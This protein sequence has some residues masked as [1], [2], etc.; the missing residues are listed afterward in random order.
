MVKCSNELVISCR[1][2]ENPPFVSPLTSTAEWLKQTCSQL[3][4]PSALLMSLLVGGLEKNEQNERQWI[5]PN[6]I[7]PWN[8]TWNL[9]MK[10]VEKEIPFGNHDFF[11][12]HVKFRG[13]NISPTYV[14][15]KGEISLT[16]HHHLGMKTRV[17]PRANLTRQNERHWRCGSED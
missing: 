4:M 3:P 12:F 13:S 11:R 2:C 14:S 15:L 16:I 1:G 8:L 5:W 7:H 17:R 9:K 10:S 6:G